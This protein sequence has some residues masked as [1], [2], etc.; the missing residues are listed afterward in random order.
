MSYLVRGI[1]GAASNAGSSGLTTST[2]LKYSILLIIISG[3]WQEH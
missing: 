2:I 1:I 3:S